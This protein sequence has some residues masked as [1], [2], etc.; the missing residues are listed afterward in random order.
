MFFLSK[1]PCISLT[2]SSLHA[3]GTLSQAQTQRRH[4][5]NHLVQRHSPGRESTDQQTNE[6][7]FFML[8]SH[9]LR[10]LDLKATWKSYEVS[11]Y[12]KTCRTLP[13]QVLGRRKVLV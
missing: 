7:S 10:I 11:E 9:Q 6:L 5:I 13:T 1:P 8:L 4:T 3:T 12:F 2:F